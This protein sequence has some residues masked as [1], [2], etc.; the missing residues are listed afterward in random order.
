MRPLLCLLVALL[1]APLAPAA[2]AGEHAPPLAI[3]GE[4]VPWADFATWLVGLRG[5]EHAREY[6]LH[7][8]LV[9]AAQAEGVQVSDE[10]LA[11]E[12]RREAEQRVERAFGGDRAAWEAE[13]ALSHLAPDSYYA[14]RVAELHEARL[15][16]EL[17]KRRRV[18]DDATLHRVWEREYGPQGQRLELSLLQ[19]PVELAEQ[20]PGATRDEV[21]ELGRK[22]RAAALAR[23]EALRARLAAGAD[24][25]ELVR[26]E[27][28]DAASRARDGRLDGPFQVQDWPG[29]DLAPL[30]ESPVGAVAPPLLSRG[31]YNL[32]R[33]DART[34][35]PFAEVRDEV[36][37]IARDA[38]VTA[39]ENE[40]LQAEL[41]ASQT[42]EVL[43]EMTRATSAAE[44]RLE[45]AVLALDGRPVTRETYA[46]WLVPQRGRAL[47]SAFVDRRTIARLAAAAGV[48]VTRVEVE[49]RAA[50]EL[51]TLVD[52]FF[53][54]DRQAWRE[55][56][57]AKGE[58]EDDARRKALLRVEHTL[59]AEKLLMATREITEEQV[60]RAWV[61][62][63]GEGGRSLEVRRILR[64]PGQPPESLR[65]R[66]EL[67]RWLAE[68]DAAALAFLASLRERALAGEDFGALAR[69]WSEDALTRDL[70]GSEPGRFRLH[71]WPDDVQDAVRAL[72]PGGIT[73][74]LSLE[75]QHFLFELQRVEV[76]PLADVHDELARDLAATRPSQVEVAGFVNAA[77][78][79]RD[80]EFLPGML[81][82]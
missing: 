75:H 8:A 20:P 78:A 28:A 3:D 58:R 22:A 36:E 23:A 82:R 80:V 40:A 15:S 60:E 68:A 67:E 38:P 26:A 4:P 81:P 53:Q 64:Q 42:L 33:V 6:A 9:R 16:E 66:E 14:T 17:A 63:Y 61:E 74:P 32:F 73:P 41:A 39:L 55:D 72:A 65:T 2:R 25:A 43:P 21:L 18:L 70:G 11:A 12:V 49:T 69:T 30:L 56:M 76:V 59:L 7:V 62:R 79:A 77:T 19:V 1:L 44:P 54:G 35:H 5:A 46:E 37:R 52:L 71:T 27:S 31:A 48:S 47:A 29:L 50:E 34:T 51:D 57:A 10:A 45:R 13:L 24:W